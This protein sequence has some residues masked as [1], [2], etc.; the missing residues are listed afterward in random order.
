MTHPEIQLSFG[1]QSHQG[2]RET[3]E[4]TV[5]SVGLPDGRWLLAVADGMGGLSAGELASKTAL[6]ALYRMLTEGSTLVEAAKEG[7]S[8]I[9]NKA[10]DQ[11]MGT[12]LVA[13]LLTGSRVELINVGDSR[14]YHLD[15]LGLLQITLDHTVG[16]EAL[17]NGT[18]DS[19]EALSSPMA[20]A[21]SR[22]LGGGEEVAVD[23]FGPFEITERGWLLLCSDGLHNVFSTAEI[24]KMLV[25]ESDPEAAA[26]RLVEEALRKGTDDNVS[27]V[28][29]FRPRE[30]SYVPFKN[31]RSASE[32]L[33]K[34]M[35]PGSHSRRHGARR[36]RKR[37]ILV[38][39]LL[40]V[41]VL[42]AVILGLLAVLGPS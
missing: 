21:L 3:N 31:R 22:Y 20:R 13:A 1:F 39:T 10:S 7:N 42:I 15:P 14:A 27:V 17:R 25:G 36:K 41:P 26:S 29:A 30:A 11:E 32:S 6:G 5:L 4:D 23:Y 2:P 24:E 38:L 16:Q 18:L 8:A 34:R 37:W 35:L 28:L 9:L 12:T 19:Q 40:G 33:S